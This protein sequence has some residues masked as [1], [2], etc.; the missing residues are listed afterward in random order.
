MFKYPTMTEKKVTGTKAGLSEKTSR[1]REKSIKAAKSAASEKK[2]KV[3]KEVPPEVLEQQ[4]KIIA[5]VLGILFIF[6]GI[7]LF[8]CFVLPYST[9][10]AGKWLY[11]SFNSLFGYG[12][13]IFPLILFHIGIQLSVKGSKFTWS[14]I[15]LFFVL[16]YIDA[17][18]LVHFITGKGGTMGTFMGDKITQVIGKAGGYLVLIFIGIGSLMLLTQ[19]TIKQ[20][21]KGTYAV[22]SFLGKVIEK[23]WHFLTFRTEDPDKEK[24]LLDPDM[25]EMPDLAVVVNG[26]AGKV[27]SAKVEKTLDESNEEMEEDEDEGPADQPKKVVFFEETDF[28]EDADEDEDE[29][30][31]DEVIMP[32]SESEDSDEQSEEIYLLPDEAE[33]PEDEEK[34]DEMPTPKGLNAA[35]TP[36]IPLGSK[37]KDTFEITGG[38]PT[39]YEELNLFGEG[40]TKKPGNSKDKTIPV[41]QPVRDYKYHFPSLNLLS[42]A[43]QKTEKSEHRDDSKILEETLANF[44]VEVKVINI[45]HGPAVTRYELQPAKGVKVR[46]ITNL[47]N[48]IALALAAYSIRIEAPI[49]GKAAIGIEVP[50]RRIE[51]VFLRDLLYDAKYKKLPPL[52]L[53]LGKDIT[54]KAVVADLLKMPHLL[55]AGATGSGKSV[56]VNSIVGSILYKATPLDVQLVM[57]DPKRVELSLY[58]GIPHLVDI[59]LP[60]G[61]KIITDPKAATMALK[62]LSEIMDMRYEDFVALKV[63]NIKEFNEKAEIPIPYIVII[64]DELADLMMVSSSTVEQYICRIAQLGRA[65][66]IHLIVATQRPSVD[67]ITGLIKA[68]IPSRIAFAVSSQVDSRTILDRVGAEKLL[69]KG[70][71][72]YLPVDASEPRR[73][74]GAYVSGEEIEKVVEFW[75]QQPPPENI[76]PIEISELSSKGN[77]SNDDETEDDLLPDA[78][79]VIKT[80]RQASVS[81]LQRKMKIGY[82]RAGRIMDQLERKGI[83]GPAQGSKPRKIMLPGF[84]DYD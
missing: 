10:V 35:D 83:V 23:T 84:T 21:L 60:G 36:K 13:Y 17:V 82:A 62:T 54:G 8:V 73:I 79:E 26:K 50:N 19:L 76:I 55:V 18:V 80:S 64:I 22:I 6:V 27:K 57:V 81:N 30:D 77:E 3:K 71:M 37:E 53:A 68:N 39:G 74:Q 69:G 51:P 31:D 1:V 14:W 66:G 43:P 70:D 9:G 56:C 75:K 44:G 15:L 16:L 46:K 42:A 5:R 63:R 24:A 4:R 78:I 34:T 38:K 32:P 48:D 58:E 7:F 47:S 29:D 65:S 49:P 67:V 45:I 72:L 2:P 33:E 11:E 28:D 61:K 20:V 52:S 12:I 40:E 59:K 41:K 25:H